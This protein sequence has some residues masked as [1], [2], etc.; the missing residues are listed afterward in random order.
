MTKC[1][2]GSKEGSATHRYATTKIQKG[3]AVVMG[4]IKLCRCVFTSDCRDI[5][6]TD[7][8]NGRMNMEWHY[9]DLCNRAKKVVK[10]D[11]YMKFYVISMP[12]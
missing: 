12:L 2:Y 4:Y 1:K 7:I 8:G 6:T 9:Q 5:C 3:A 11:A 10:T